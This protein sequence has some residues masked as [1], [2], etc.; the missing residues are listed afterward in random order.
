MIL[1]K[2]LYPSTLLA[3]FQLAQQELLN[4]AQSHQEKIWGY[5]PALSTRSTLPHCAHLAR[6]LTQIVCDFTLQD[7]VFAF[8]RVSEKREQEEVGHLHLDSRQDGRPMAEEALKQTPSL[9]RLLLNLSDQPRTLLYSPLN[10]NE[11]EK[12]GGRLV[13]AG[14]TL[15]ELPLGANLKTIEI[16]PRQNDTLWCLEFCAS[17]TPHAG[18]EGLE[19][20]FLA[21]FGAKE[22]K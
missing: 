2:I 4:A 15:V 5:F 1:K 14:Y 7:W 10:T 3:L 17:S 22:T 21:A 20:H 8:L 18:V 19:G 6:E 16:P 13:K 11:I 12:Q 9:Q